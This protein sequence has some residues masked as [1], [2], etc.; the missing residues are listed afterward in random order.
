M[1]TM[2]SCD[3]PTPCFRVSFHTDVSYATFPNPSTIR[4][5]Q[6]GGYNK[7]PEYF[8]WVHRPLI[9]AWGKLWRFNTKYIEKDLKV[10]FLGKLLNP[11]WLHAHFHFYT[12]PTPF[13]F[14]YLSSFQ[15][16]NQSTNQS[17]NQSVNQSINQSI[18]QSIHKWIICYLLRSSLPSFPPSLPYF[19]PS[20]PLLSLI[21]REAIFIFP[22]SPD[23][24]RCTSR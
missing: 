5:L 3:C 22:F 13:P 16:I 8:R 9:F 6:K 24:T 20:A 21:P 19:L 7:N 10:F 1:T 15:S 4:M 11:L 18:S 23:K 17:I 12:L 2:Q 14:S